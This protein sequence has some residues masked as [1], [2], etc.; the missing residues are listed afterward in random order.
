MNRVLPALIMSLACSACG[1]GHEDHKA[2][3][4]KWKMTRYEFQGE[5]KTIEQAAPILTIEDGKG[6]FGLEGGI[7]KFSYTIDPSQTPKH[8]DI[9]YLGPMLGGARALDLY[10]LEGDRLTICSVSLRDGGKTRPSEFTSVG[11]GNA[12]VQYE[13]VGDAR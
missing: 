4:G 8:L 11:R 2:L 7:G 3:L 12:V 5:L 1:P 13:R 6:D 9:T 10:K